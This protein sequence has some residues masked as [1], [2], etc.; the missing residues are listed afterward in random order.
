MRHAATDII[1]GL[2]KEHDALYVRLLDHRAREKG[3]L[4]STEE[5]EALASEVNT[6]LD[7]MEEIAPEIRLLN[8]YTW[9]INAS[10][11]WQAYASLL[12]ISRKIKIPQP[13]DY[14][15]WAPTQRLGKD[16][17]D[18][19]LASRERDICRLR[20]LRN[21]Y[22]KSGT[23]FRT[24]T[25]RTLPRFTLPKMRSMVRMHLRSKTSRD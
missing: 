1:E 8:D 18:H 23:L 21:F 14:G 25:T 11:Q 7:K 19:W 2:K 5:H 22:R 17:V 20:H 12:N 3:T 4:E 16:D 6:L 15:L 10:M 13:P 24:L 9:L